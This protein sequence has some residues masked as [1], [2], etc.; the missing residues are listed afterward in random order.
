MTNINKKVE[1][2][3]NSATRSPQVHDAVLLVENTK[4]DFS[5][6]FSYGGKDADMLINS[7]S[8]GKMY[9]AAIILILWEQKRLTLDDLLGKYFEKP[10]LDGLHI[11]KGAEYSHKLTIADLLFQTSGLPDY[12]E[13]GG[14]K[15]DLAKSDFMLSFADGLS[16]TKKLKPHFAPGTA[17]KVYYS[18]FNFDLLGEIIKNITNTPLPKTYK[19]FLFDPLGLTKTY[20]PASEQNII[21]NIRYKGESLYRPKAILSC[22]ASGGIV[23]TAREM[24]LFLKAFWNGTFFSKNMFEKIA[25]YRKLPF[26]NKKGPIWYGGGYMQIPLRTLLTLYSGKGE[27][28]GHSGATSCGAFYYP[29]KDLFFVCDFN[30]VANPAI[31]IKLTM[32]LAMS[33]K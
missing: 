9:T 16:R 4:G 7:A 22:S 5:A 13:E 6:S 10:V 8:I 2:I 3:F 11:Y 19:E 30:Q 32:R 26:S 15:M 27:L 14:T 33:V 12:T 20:L 21:P 28:I 17:H 25:V 31:P 23:T 18:D 24:M 1:K 29:Y